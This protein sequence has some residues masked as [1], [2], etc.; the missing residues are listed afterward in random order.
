MNEC[1]MHK[2]K[3]TMIFTNSI[4]GLKQDQIIWV[5]SRSSGCHPVYKISG[6]DPD[7]VLDHAHVLTVASGPDQ[8]NELSM[9]GGHNGSVSPDLYFEC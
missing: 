4:F 3:L 5:L 8:S 2:D 9:L 7:S 6:S 1:F